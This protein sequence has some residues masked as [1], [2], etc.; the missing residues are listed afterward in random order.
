MNDQTDKQKLWKIYGILMGVMV[1]G[2][3]LILGGQAAWNAVQQNLAKYTVENKL[4]SS[5][6]ASSNAPSVTISPSNSSQSLTAYNPFDN[7]AFPLPSCGDAKPINPNAYPVNFYP[8]FIEYSEINL[9]AVRSRFCGD[10][11]PMV[12][13]MTGKN[14]IQIA[15]F[16][17]IE[18]ADAFKKIM[19]RS[20]G[21]SE[22]G[23]PRKV[24]YKE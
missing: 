12:R 6:S 21:N 20:F 18:R 24:E 14:A 23:E 9:Q 1:G 2:S 8:V 4:Q 17:S 7:V 11:Y 10:A 3:V 22:V 15:S 19:I 13:K 5:N 16:T